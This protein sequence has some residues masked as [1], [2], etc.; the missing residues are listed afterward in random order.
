MLGSIKPAVGRPGAHTGNLVNSDNT[1][2]CHHTAG[3]Q[4]VCTGV[5]L[6]TASQMHA[7]SFTA[8]QLEHVYNFIQAE[9]S[10]VRRLG[11][12]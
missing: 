11:S 6:C 10:L 3:I 8:D 1:N 4:L 2:M 12:H 5:M 7:A 9:G